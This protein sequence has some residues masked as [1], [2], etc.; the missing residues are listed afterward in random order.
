MSVFLDTGIYYALQNEGAN[1]HVAARSAFSSAL[2]GRFGA[3]FTS[4]YVFDELVTLVYARTGNF[5]EAW[6]AARRVLGRDNFPD[7]VDM[8]FI[9]R[10]S[11]DAAVDAFERYDDQGLSFTDATT[12]SLVEQHD[13]DRVLAFDD[14]FDGVV[15][16][17]DPVAV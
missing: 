15:D 11:F 8:L 6:T 10:E 16:R 12:V 13:I 4:D 3:V 2:P 17:V 9:D 14:D 7:A 5:D 1:R